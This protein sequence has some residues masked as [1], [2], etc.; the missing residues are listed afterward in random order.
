MKFQYILLSIFGVI[1]VVAVIVFATAPAENDGGNANIPNCV[2]GDVVIWG[3]YPQYGVDTALQKFNEA[4]RDCFTVLYQYHDPAKFDRDIVEAIASKRGP[5]ILLLPDDL[6]L[7]HY[8]KVEL[9]PYQVFP[10]LAFRDMF[11]QA[12][13]IFMM[14]KG[15]VA[16]PFAID[17]IVMYWNRDIFGNASLTQTPKH[18]DELLTLAPTL[19]KRDQRTGD[20]VQSAVPFGEFANVERAKEMLATLFLQVGSPIVRIVG[21]RPFAA[22]ADENGNQIVPNQNV[23]FSFRFFMDFSNPR[24]NIYSWN[25]AKSSARNEFI[26]GKL[27]LYFDYA[28]A[29]QAIAE[30]NPHLNFA[31]AAVPQPRDT[32]VE[33]TYA[34]VHGLA[35]L[36]D[37]RN[38]AAAPVVARYLLTDPVAQK[39]FSSQ[40]NLPPIRRDLLAN[41]PTDPALAV[42]YSSAIRARTW[43]DPEPGA[44]ADA[45][46]SAVEAVSSGRESSDS[47]IGLLHRSLSTLLRD[48]RL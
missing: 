21:D 43:L 35:V 41:P 8:D 30:K 44:S 4:Y 22:L 38:K 12:G 9:V 36:K 6:I 5:D 23:V 3:T 24:K 10:P 18:W 26:N 2:K 15:I 17:P 47:G 11:A 19:T 25:R 31:V 29:Y 7:R 16:Y 1:G 20:I 48:Y 42:F 13:E 14:E 34:K 45:F 32:K 39:E 37:A 40:F 33:I 27:A 28:S 46:R